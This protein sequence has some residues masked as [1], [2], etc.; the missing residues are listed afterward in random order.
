MSQARLINLEI[1]SIERFQAETIVVIRNFAAKK[2]ST[3][4]L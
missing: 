4:N 3:I 2:A 1:L